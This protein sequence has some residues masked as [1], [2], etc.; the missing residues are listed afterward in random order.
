MDVAHIGG[1]SFCGSINY[2]HKYTIF[3][4][5]RQQKIA[6][7]INKIKGFKGAGDS[8]R[9]VVLTGRNVEVKRTGN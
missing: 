6:T 5:P 7:I 2:F 8:T 1:A 4:T 9:R 3:R